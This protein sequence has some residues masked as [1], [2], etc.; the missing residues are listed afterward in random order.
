MLKHKQ[1]NPNNFFDNLFFWI[2]LASVDFYF[3]FGNFNE[4]ENVQGS[5]KEAGMGNQEAGI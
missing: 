1:K 5:S 2:Q 3:V 4:I